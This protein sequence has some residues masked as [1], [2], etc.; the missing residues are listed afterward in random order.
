MQTR[1]I[2]L[3]EDN[4]GEYL[5]ELGVGQDFLNQVVTKKGNIDK[6]NIIKIKN[7]YLSRDTIKRVKRQVT[8]LE[9]IFATYVADKRHVWNI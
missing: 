9:K 4:I 3:L 6:L 1:G 7:V 8:G 5:Y 2:I